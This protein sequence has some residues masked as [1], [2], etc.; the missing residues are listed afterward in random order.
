MRTLLPGSSTG[1]A[2]A[3]P[4]LTHSGSAAAMAAML[5]LF[6]DGEAAE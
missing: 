2:T 1:T 6:G 4:S 5:P 3:T